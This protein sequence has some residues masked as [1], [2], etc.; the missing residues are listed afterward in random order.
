MLWQT[1]WPEGGSPLAVLPGD[2]AKVWGGDDHGDPERI[3]VTWRA[4]VDLPEHL[5]ARMGDTSFASLAEA[6][7]FLAEVEAEVTRLHPAAVKSEI[8]T[9]G[10]INHALAQQ[11]AKAKGEPAPPQQ[12][13]TY[14]LDEGEDVLLYVDRCAAT[15]F[16]VTLADARQQEI[17]EDDAGDADACDR[18][19]RIVR[20][21]DHDVLLF[22]RHGPNKVL[23]GE[24]DDGTVVLTLP[25][26]DEDD[27]ELD[28]DDEDAADDRR[29]AQASSTL[30]AIREGRQIGALTCPSDEIVVRFAPDA[31][32]VDEPEM[33]F[34]A[35]ARHYV[36]REGRVRATR[37]V[38][39]APAL[40]RS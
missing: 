18:C 19:G 28:E 27:E 36:V 23:V 5:L 14:R 8:P 22:F 16:R 32:D 6:E 20:L 7:R 34:R 12:R 21:R 29:E 39:V 17:A 1:I 37:W 30:S 35:R 3:L 40:P 24:L 33:S 31:A 13:L 4:E 38:A 11:L 25:E 26:D 9:W 15:D 10:Y 2:L